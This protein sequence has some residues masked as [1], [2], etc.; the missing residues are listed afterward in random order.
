MG[1]V[2]DSGLGQSGYRYP[3]E[4]NLFELPPMETTYLREEVV[5]YRP[6][7]SQILPDQYIQY[8][9]PASI[10]H[11]TSL[12][13]SRHHVRVRIVK[14]D[15]S[16]PEVDD[17][18]CAPVQWPGVS[19]FESCVL[20]LQQQLVSCTGGQDHGYRGVMEAFLD[21]HR[22]DKD[23][24]LQSGLFISDSPGKMDD[25]H[26]PYTGFMERFLYFSFGREVDSLRHCFWTSLSS[27]V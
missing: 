13:E 5:D 9:I 4:L 1:E 26:S 3:A 10:S 16:L 7:S 24:I 15:G 23:T 11:F 22:F 18:P 19:L 17:D 6:I 8:Q 27:V 12:A 2:K 21:R 14:A 25:F 20:Y